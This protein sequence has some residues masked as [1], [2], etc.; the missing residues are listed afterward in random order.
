[1]DEMAEEFG[2]MLR[3]REEEG[4]TEE[5]GIAKLAYA[6][7]YNCMIC[8]DNIF[9]IISMFYSILVM[10]LCTNNTTGNAGENA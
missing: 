8:A 7:Y 4:R 10:T 9:F 5:I 3:V 2:E 1:M 6:I